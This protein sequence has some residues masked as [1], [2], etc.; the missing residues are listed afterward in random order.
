MNRGDVYKIE[1]ELP[2]RSGS[3]TEVREKY[4]VALQ[5]G[6]DF[7]NVTEVA[8]VIASTYRGSGAVRPFEVLVGPP[9]GFHHT[10]VIDGRWPATLPK[11]QL[12]AGRLLTTLAPETMWRVSRAIA[13]GLQ[14][15]PPT[16]P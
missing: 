7:A 10:T 6:S 8:V 4:V 5:G 15:K 1:L 3:G 13:S 14:M 12:H 2:N 16:V 11:A 9:E